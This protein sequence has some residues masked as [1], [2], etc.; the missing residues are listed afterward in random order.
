MQPAEITKYGPIHARERD[1]ELKDNTH[2]E[3]NTNLIVLPV[4]VHFAKHFLTDFDYVIIMINGSDKPCVFLIRN[5]GTCAFF[6]CFP[7]L[8]SLKSLWKWTIM[9][10]HTLTLSPVE[11]PM[12]HCHGDKL[13]CLK[14]TL[15]NCVCMNVSQPS[16]HYVWIGFLS[17]YL[18]SACLQEV[19]VCS[20]AF[21]TT[22]FVILCVHWLKLWQV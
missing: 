18:E 1:D 5:T 14:L 9:A 6:P 8:S 3:I 13:A 16:L 17:S 21:C 4:D 22:D 20:P 12:S 11:F 7:A 10:V 2:K 19:C 15:H